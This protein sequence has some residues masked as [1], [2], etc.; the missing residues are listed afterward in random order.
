MH[1]TLRSVAAF[2]AWVATMPLAVAEPRTE[3]INAEFLYSASD[4][5]HVTYQRAQRVAKRA[6]DIHGEMGAQVARREHACEQDLLDQFVE[7]IHKPDLAAIHL[8]K[9]GR[10][11]PIDNRVAT[12]AMQDDS[13]G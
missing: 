3:A 5:L 1:S 4:P 12:S 2:S 11:S 7:H 6:C 9:K 10:V 8:N 13:A